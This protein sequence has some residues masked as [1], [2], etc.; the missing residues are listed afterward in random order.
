[1]RETGIALPQAA[2]D[3]QALSHVSRTPSLALVTGAASRTHCAA[4]VTSSASTSRG[5]RP[6]G[7]LSLAFAFRTS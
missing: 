4:A 3:G 7:L 2:G 6:A 5:S 1:M